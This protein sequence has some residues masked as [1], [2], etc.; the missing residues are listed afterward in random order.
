MFLAG[1]LLCS[2]LRKLIQVPNNQHIV[3]WKIISITIFPKQINKCLCYSSISTVRVKLCKSDTLHL[4]ST[5]LLWKSQYLFTTIKTHTIPCSKPQL[6]AIGN[7]CSIL[8]CVIFHYLIH[9]TVNTG[10]IHVC[11]P[12]RVAQRMLNDVLHTPRGVHEWV[13]HLCK[14]LMSTIKWWLT[15][16]LHWCTMLKHFIYSLPPPPPP[17]F[18]CLAWACIPYISNYG[19]LLKSNLWGITRCMP[20]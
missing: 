13:F 8:V 10:Y 9:T 20:M 7:W 16:M 3:N 4:L 15:R 17:R 14:P 5:A 19:I 2:L 1:G 12:P 18:P 6:N 11:P